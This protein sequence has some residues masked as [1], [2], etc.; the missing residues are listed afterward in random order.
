VIS[1]RNDDPPSVTHDIDLKSPD[2]SSVIVDHDVIPGGQ[3]TQYQ[4]E[5]LEPGTYPF[6]CSVHPSVPAMNGTLT[7]Q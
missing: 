5:A 4:F 6:F 1:F 3:S 2:G 7:V